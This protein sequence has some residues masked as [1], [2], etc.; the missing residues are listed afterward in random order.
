MKR[1][2]RFAQ[3]PNDVVYS[4]MDSPVG[5]LTIFASDKGIYSILW[6][7]EASSEQ[8]TALKKEYQRDDQHGLILKTKQQLQAY[9]QG[10]RQQFDLPIIFTGT[11]FQIQAWEQLQQIPYGQTISYGEQAARLGDKKK[12]R[13]VGMANG[14]NPISIVVPCH[15]VIG[16]NG[17][18]TGFGGGLEN[19]QKLLEMESAT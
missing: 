11:D 6:D 10:Q 12:A 9:F 3:F 15:R 17:S 14:M 16:A 8:V 2:K 4:D 1:L 19:K 18:L 5:C 7:K 13:A